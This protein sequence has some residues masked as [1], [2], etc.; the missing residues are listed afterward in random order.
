M[1]AGIRVTKNLIA[2]GRSNRSDK[3]NLIIQFR[4]D[5]LVKI[6]LVLDDARD[7][8]LSARAA[9][10]LNC[11]MYSFVGMDTADKGEIVSG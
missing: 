6:L 7:N 8:Q 1:Q 4:L 2:L 11:V 9:C 3:G 10:Y 5:R